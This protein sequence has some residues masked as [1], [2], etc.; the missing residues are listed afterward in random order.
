MPKKK[1]RPN[2]PKRSPYEAEKPKPIE[3][4][5]DQ[6]LFDCKLANRGIAELLWDI[7]DKE[8][9]FDDIRLEAEAVMAMYS[10]IYAEMKELVNSYEQ[11]EGEL[12]A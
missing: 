3:T 6:V 2:R 8:K 5:P 4:T 1:R 11:Q 10:V 12:R 7:T 9:P